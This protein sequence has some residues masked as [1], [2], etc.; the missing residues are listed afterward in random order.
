MCKIMEERV[1]DAEYRKAIGIATNPIKLGTLSNEQIS[2]AT[3]L[4]LETVIELAEQLK[5]VPA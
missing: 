5:D 4:S 1:K 3:G 2:E